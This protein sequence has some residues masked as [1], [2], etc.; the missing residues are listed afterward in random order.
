MGNGWD[1]AG[2]VSRPTRMLCDMRDA[3]YMG[4]AV[5]GVYTRA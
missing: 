2:F 5:C 4:S 3:S 1:A